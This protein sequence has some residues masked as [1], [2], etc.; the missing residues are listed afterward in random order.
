MAK[1][2]TALVIGN[3]ADTRVKKLG[4]PVHDAD[5]VAVKLEAHGFTVFKATDCS[6]KERKWLSNRTNN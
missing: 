6:L 3:A 4:H 5:D 2:P 1:H